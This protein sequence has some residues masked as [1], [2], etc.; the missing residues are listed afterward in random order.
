M[1]R[2]KGTCSDSLRE[3]LCSR[4]NLAL[5]ATIHLGSKLIEF[6]VL[7]IGVELIQELVSIKGQKLVC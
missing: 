1:D 2:V 5:S 7:L 6:Q 3:L 4:D